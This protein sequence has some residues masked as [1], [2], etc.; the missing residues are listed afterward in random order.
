[1]RDW[2]FGIS[3]VTQGTGDSAPWHS[4][5]NTGAGK[6]PIRLNFDKHGP[7]TPGRRGH[8]CAERPT[9]EGKQKKSCSKNRAEN[10][11]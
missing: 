8:R 6:Q 5:S 9:Q 2:R 10:N 4:P 7:V 1:M 11:I 3:S